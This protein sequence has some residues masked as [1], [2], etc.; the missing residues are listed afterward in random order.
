MFSGGKPLVAGE[1]TGAWAGTVQ[2]GGRGGPTAAATADFAANGLFG[3]ASKQLIDFRCVLGS[4]WVAL[5][6]L[7]A[8]PVHMHDRHV[9]P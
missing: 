1:A 6:W 2:G 7:M 4:A 5:T 9:P 8:S 3:G